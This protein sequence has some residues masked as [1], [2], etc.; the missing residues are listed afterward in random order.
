MPS[1]LL[2]EAEEKGLITWHF[3]IT[4]DHG[5]QKRYIIKNAKYEEIGVIWTRNGLVSS[6][7][8]Y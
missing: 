1:G 5:G 3:R 7:N 6:I 2:L 8:Y 4:S